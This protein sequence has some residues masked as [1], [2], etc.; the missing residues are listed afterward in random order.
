MDDRYY[1]DFIG[2][3]ICEMLWLSY[4]AS[5]FQEK[6]AIFNLQIF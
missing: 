6:H 3:S 1:N 5:P 2:I 4:F